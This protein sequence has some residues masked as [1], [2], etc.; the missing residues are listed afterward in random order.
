MILCETTDYD[1]KNINYNIKDCLDK[2]DPF[3]VSMDS[4]DMSDLH[5]AMENPSVTNAM[6]ENPPKNDY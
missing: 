1:K 5:V 3:E 4:M 2:N 6:Q